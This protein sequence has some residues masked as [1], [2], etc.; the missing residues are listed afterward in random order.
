MLTIAY[1]KA[2][3]RLICGFGVV[4]L[5]FSA[6]AFSQGKINSLEVFMYQGADREKKLIENDS[7]QREQG[8]V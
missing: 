2:A 4:A 8:K 5:M 7:E 3:R 6:T 1:R